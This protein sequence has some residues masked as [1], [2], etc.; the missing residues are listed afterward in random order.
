MP[1]TISYM[2]EEHTSFIVDFCVCLLC[3]PAMPASFCTHF[4][5]T[6]MLVCLLIDCS[7][8]QSDSCR[9]LGL[10]VWYCLPAK[11]F[12]DLFI[13]HLFYLASFWSIEFL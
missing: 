9:A 11:Y 3:L 12:G 4:T 10:I 7:G 8:H 5:L 2:I 1:E 13:R 6:N